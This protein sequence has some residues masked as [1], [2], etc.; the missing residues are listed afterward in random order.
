LSP[1][2]RAHI[3]IET[4]GRQGG[5]VRRQNHNSTR[6]STHD[7]QECSSY[8]YGVAVLWHDGFE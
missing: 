5:R 4:F 6:L 2:N 3:V 7:G 8:R 1:P